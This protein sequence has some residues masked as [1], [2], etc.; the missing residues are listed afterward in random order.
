[1]RALPLFCAASALLLTL[2]LPLRGQP[3]PRLAE[4]ERGVALQAPGRPGM[5]VNYW[6]YE[7]NMFDAV[8]RGQP[9]PSALTRNDPLCCAQHNGS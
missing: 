9:T 3:K 5:A 7:W 1:M 2:S 6:F 8:L 4:W